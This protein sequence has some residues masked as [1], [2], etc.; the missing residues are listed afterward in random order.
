M[1]WYYGPLGGLAVALYYGDSWD[2]YM[3]GILVGSKFGTKIFEGIGKGIAWGGKTAWHSRAGTAARG[4][5]A[6][7]ALFAAQA[8]TA[9]ALPVTIGGLASVAINGQQGLDDY[10]N[11]MTG[12]VGPVKWFKTVFNPDIGGHAVNPKHPLL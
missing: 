11:F 9:V 3:L 6:T 12:K 7:G 2:E 1:S 5:T 4:A 10:T 8:V